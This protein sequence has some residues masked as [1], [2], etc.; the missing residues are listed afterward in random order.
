M[1]IGENVDRLY[2]KI[3]MITAD[4]SYRVYLENKYDS[5]IQKSNNKQKLLEY[6]KAKVFP[7]KPDI[8]INDMITKYAKDVEKIRMSYRN[9]SAHTNE[10]KKLMQRNV[11]TMYWMWKKS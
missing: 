1:K 11:L 7:G 6:C 9:P 8:E 5:S 2:P 10:L 3:R 4:P